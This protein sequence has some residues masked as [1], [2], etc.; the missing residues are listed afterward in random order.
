[1]LIEALH[2]CRFG[3]FLLDCKKLRMEAELESRTVSVWTWL[4]GFRSQLTEPTFAGNKTLNPPV[5]GLLKRVAVWES[6]FLRWCAQPLLHEPPVDSA[7]FFPENAQRI[8]TWRLPQG[9]MNALAVALSARYQEALLVQKL[10]D[11]VAALEQQLRE[12]AR[13]QGDSQQQEEGR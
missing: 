12:L 13:A 1:M 9:T 6:V 5:A 11:R 7:S 4:N 2:S 3:T 10:G 8:S